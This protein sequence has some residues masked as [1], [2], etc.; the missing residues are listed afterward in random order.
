MNGGQRDRER[1]KKTEKKREREK[2]RERERQTEREKVGFV[3]LNKLA[4]GFEL[5]NIVEIRLG[6][7]STCKNKCPRHTVDAHRGGG[8]RGG[9]S[10][11]PYKDF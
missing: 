3:F 7:S 10:Y 2:D 11:T 4:V 5:I 9:T 8:E 1:E 6:H